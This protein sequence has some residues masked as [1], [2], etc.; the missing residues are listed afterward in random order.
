MKNQEDR[1]TVGGVVLTDQTGNI[2]FKNTFDTR[3]NI[4][5]ENIY[6]IITAMLWGINSDH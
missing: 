3:L 4:A 2:V 6:P 5:K 1:K